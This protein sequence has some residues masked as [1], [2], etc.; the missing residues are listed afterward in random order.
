MNKSGM[1]SAAVFAIG[2]TVPTP[3]LFSHENVTTTVTFDRE[4]VR[5]L[6]K[7]CMFCHSRRNL[8]V[9]LTSY[10]ET[11]PWARSIEE[12]VLTRHMPPWRAVAGYG[13]FANDVGMTNRETQ[14]IVAWVE[15]NGPKSKDQQVLAN[16]GDPDHP[17]ERFKPSFEKWLL[18]QPDLLKPLPSNSIAAS[19]GDSVRRVN[20]DAGL[21][22]EKWIRALEFKPGDRRVVRA[23]FFSVQETG[24]WLGSWTPWY[25]ATTLPDNTAY[26]L[27]AG[28]H[29]TAEIHYRGADEPVEDKSTLALYFAAKPAAHTPVDLVLDARGAVTDTQKVTRT[30]T[31]TSDARVLSFRP[32][33]QEGIES[34]DVTAREPDGSVRVMLLVRHA[35][36][37]WPTPYILSQPVTLPKNTELTVNGYYSKPESHPALK[38][39][40]SLY[41]P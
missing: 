28:S 1:I 25:G 18:G 19:G 16:F 4:I 10:E 39:T 7:K 33:L 17:D 13:Q 22:S 23:A 21:M 15:G 27:P 38:L 20:I 40:V 35:L 41:N 36:P 31:L 32:D 5:I 26:R 12:E 14:F 34:L 30:V 3:P 8:A 37:E 6:N 11:R 24:Q 9:P 29:I 2:L